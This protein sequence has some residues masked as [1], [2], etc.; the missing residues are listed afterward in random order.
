MPVIVPAA[1]GQATPKSERT[2]GVSTVT[3][4]LRG[5][6][7]RQFAGSRSQY[8]MFKPCK[9][10]RAS[11]MHAAI[12]ITAEISQG[13]PFAAIAFVRS[14]CPYHGKTVY[15]SGGGQVPITCTTPGCEHR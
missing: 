11:A 12:L 5:Q 13:P 3:T 8:K 10:I 2:H 1:D 7:N 9:N 4:W 15:A 6:F 14:P